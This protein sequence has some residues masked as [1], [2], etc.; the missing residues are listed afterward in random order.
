MS[1]TARSRQVRSDDLPVGVIGA[2]AIGGTVA[3]HLR[4]GAVPGCRLAGVLLRRRRPQDPDAVNSID[5]LLSRS[6]LIVEAAGH[7]VVR[8]LGPLILAGGA[9]LLVVSVG[10]LAEDG[11]L[12]R[13]R[14]SGDG[15][16]LL[17]TGAIGGLDVLRAAMRCGPLKE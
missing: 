6:A 5:E 14:R 13:L 1:Q 9:D 11:L 15:R 3:R 17:S 12:N 4:R 7:Q 16:I 8:E 10:A 2:G